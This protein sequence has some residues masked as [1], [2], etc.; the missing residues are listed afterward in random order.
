MTAAPAHIHPTAAVM[1]SSRSAS[2][3]ISSSV[4]ASMNPPLSPWLKPSVRVLNPRCSVTTSKPP[5]PVANPLIIVSIKAS[6][7]LEP[8]AAAPSSSVASLLL[9]LPTTGLTNDGGSID[10]PVLLQLE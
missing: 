2:G 4:T 1:E 8:K 9:L 10:G 6:P 7:M 3:R 5:R